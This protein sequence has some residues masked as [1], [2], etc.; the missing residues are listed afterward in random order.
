MRAT[1][2]DREKN[3]EKHYNGNTER[4]EKKLARG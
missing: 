4:K 2:K 1:K 3:R